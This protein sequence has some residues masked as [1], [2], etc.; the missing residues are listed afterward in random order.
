MSSVSWV[1]WGLVFLVIGGLWFAFRRSGIAPKLILLVVVPFLLVLALVTLKGPVGRPSGSGAAVG[2]WLTPEERS[3][4]DLSGEFKSL[5]G[6]T[7]SLSDFSGKVL[8]L[9]VWATWCG[10]CRQEMPSMAELYR[11]FAGQ[12][13]SMIAVSSED[14][15]TV[16]DYAAG[17][18]YPFTIMIDSE[19]VLGRRF[20]INAIPTTFIVD[21]QGQL[22]YQHVGYNDWSSS[23]VR[24]QIRDL[25]T[26]E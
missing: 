4:I 6:R 13:L 25:L 20:G 8:F 21:K 26:N 2:N 19:D 24:E 1:G 17:S 7:I 15:E 14:L 16:R 12:G 22:V 23:T 9:N 3:D 5:D 11:E 10:P 18:R